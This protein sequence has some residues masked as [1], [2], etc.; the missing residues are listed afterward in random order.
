[1]YESIDDKS[2]QPLIFSQEM[3]EKQSR[4][5]KRVTD[6]ENAVQPYVVQPE[7]GFGPGNSKNARVILLG[8]D[9]VTWKTL[10]PLLEKGLM[11]NLKKLLA[12]SSYG[13]MATDEACSPISWTSIATGKEKSVNFS[14]TFFNMP[15]RAKSNAIQS[16]RIWQILSPATSKGKGLAIINY[17]FTPGPDEYPMGAL[18]ELEPPLAYPAGYFENSANPFPY[19]DTAPKVLKCINTIIDEGKFDN[20]FSIVR[21]TDERQHNDFFFFI[22]SRIDELARTYQLDPNFENQFHLPVNDLIKL[23]R[24]IDF[25]IGKIMSKYPDDYLFIVSDHGFTVDNPNIYLTPDQGFLDQ[26]APGLDSRPALKEIVRTNA[27]GIDV[28]AYHTWDAYG[29]PLL[30]DKSSKEMIYELIKPSRIIF[31]PDPGA[32][33]SALETIYKHILK[34]AAKGNIE[35]ATLFQVK[36][37]ESSVELYIPYKVVLAHH[38]TIRSTYFGNFGP[39]SVHTEFNTHTYKDPGVIIASGPGIARGN[40]IPPC[41]L[42]DVTPTLLYLKGHPVGKDMKGRVLQEIIDPARLQK[43]PVRMIDTHD[44]ASFLKSRNVKPRDLSSKELEK[45]KSLGYIQ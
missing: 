22:F 29:F 11:P 38:L 6:I 35:N 23:Y 42:F 33:P 10:T 32:G 1:M 17:Y 21:E 13:W 5:W 36:K 15:W 16:R 41:I 12:R 28:T 18:F 19:Q 31:K 8:L 2:L 7:G 40:L 20:L 34:M 37:T 3:T 25:L 24:N 30:T 45:L 27:A 43:S 9:G 39:I 26:I 4:N 14:D 44:D